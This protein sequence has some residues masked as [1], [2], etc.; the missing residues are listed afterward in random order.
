MP[1]KFPFRTAVF[2]VL[3]RLAIGWH[4]AYEGYHKIHSLSVGPTTTNKP[5]SSAGY[6]GEAHGPLGDLMRHAIGDPD[7]RLLERLD[8]GPRHSD[9][10]AALARDWTAYF[11]RFASHY[12]LDAGQRAKAREKLAQAEAR[13]L[14][15]LTAASTPSTKSYPSGTVEITEPNLHR[16]EEYRDAVRRL[17][18]VYAKELP[19]FGKDVEKAR[20]LKIKVEVGELRKSLETDLRVQTDQMRKSLAEVLTDDQRKLDAPPEP[21]GD[22][23]L[24]NLDVATAWF[25]FGVG[26]TLLFG[27]LTRTS[28]LLA[29]GFLLVTYLSTPAFP[30][31]PAPP[32]Q[33]GSY[34]FVSKNVIEM[35]ALLTLATT[36][37]GRWFG[38][39]AMLHQIGKAVF[40]RR[41]PRDEWQNPAP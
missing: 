19:A 38:I 28:C 22:T 23:F 32:Q 41:A 7:E 6:F 15:W 21:E 27:L 39:D 16:V 34:Y 14:K 5:F 11:D 31:L 20:L 35:L 3:L 30:W 10:P 12:A 36:P 40:A 18:E 24:K 2:L 29:A 33:E 17:R 26:L 9:V 4:F 1:W 25:L 13:F 8:A 37:S